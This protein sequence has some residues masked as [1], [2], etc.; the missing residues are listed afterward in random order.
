MEASARY[1]ACIALTNMPQNEEWEIVK[2]LLVIYKKESKK[3]RSKYIRLCDR[4]ELYV[5][6]ELLTM[7]SIDA[8]EYN[9]LMNLIY[10]NDLGNNQEGDG[11]YEEIHEAKEYWKLGEMDSKT[12]KKIHGGKGQEIAQ[13]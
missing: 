9:H 1:A 8:D 2:R 10:K 3:Q 5:I 13:K 7:L 11:M 6:P 12:A 4:R